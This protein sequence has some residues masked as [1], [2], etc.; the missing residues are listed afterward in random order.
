MKVNA[1]AIATARERMIRDLAMFEL[2]ELFPQIRFW[3]KFSQ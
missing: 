2:I 3:R 1:D